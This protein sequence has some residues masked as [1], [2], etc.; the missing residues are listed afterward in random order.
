MIECIQIVSK[1]VYWK[2]LIVIYIFILITLGNSV[3]FYLRKELK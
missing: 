2:S 3:T 1:F